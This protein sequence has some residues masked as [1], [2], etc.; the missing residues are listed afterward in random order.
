MFKKLHVVMVSVSLAMP[1]PVLAGGFKGI[2]HRKRSVCIC[3]PVCV[4]GPR[5]ECDTCSYEGASKDFRLTNDCGVI[6]CRCPYPGSNFGQA[7]G[8]EKCH[9]YA[10]PDVE[11]DDLPTQ[12]TTELTGTVF[13]L[14]DAVISL[15]V[16][17]RPTEDNFASSGIDLPTA[18]G[19]AGKVEAVLRSKHKAFSGYSNVRIAFK[20]TK[21]SSALYAT[22]F[23][24]DS[25]NNGNQYWFTF[26]EVVNRSNTWRHFRFHIFANQGSAEASPKQFSIARTVGSS[27]V[28]FN[29]SFVC[30]FE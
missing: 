13:G 26:P 4:A 30:H 23:S 22:T 1:T 14:D 10:P 8:F 16:A 20:I 28:F 7:Q 27:T 15:P 9:R 21:T 3:P 24:T 6:G 17:S 2:F 29:F 12:S 19:E 25:D 18:E 5:G 11:R